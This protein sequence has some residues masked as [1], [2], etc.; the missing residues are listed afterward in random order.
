M[1]KVTQEMVDELMGA[2]EIQTMRLG[3][4]TTVMVAILPNGFEITESSSCVDP[5]NYDEAIGANICR[6]RIM[7]KVWELTGY[8]LQCAIAEGKLTTEA[9]EE[10]GEN[11]ELQELGK[12]LTATQPEDTER[13]QSIGLKVLGYSGTLMDWLRGWLRSYDKEHGTK[14]EEEL[15]HWINQ[16]PATS[17]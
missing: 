13:L 9:T 3:H 10:H 15:P 14:L 8:R 4:K 2:A 6:G 17:M 16:Q 12:M 5:A 7:E 11:T 1:N